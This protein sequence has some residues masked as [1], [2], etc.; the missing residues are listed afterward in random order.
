MKIGITGAGGYIGSRVTKLALEEGY[1]VVPIDNGYNSQVQEV[2]GEKV[3]DQDVRNIEGLKEKFGDVDAIFHLA[4]IT[5]IPECEEKE[6][7]AYEVNVRGTENIARICSENGIPLVF[8]M[9]MQVFGKVKEFPIT[10]E[11]SRRPVNNYGITKT[12]SE[13][14]IELLSK[15]S[16]P[17]YVFIKSNVYGTHEIKDKEIS[18]GTVMNYFLD[19]AKKGEDLTVHSP[20]TQ[21]K[22]FIHVKDVAKAYIKSLDSLIDGN[23]G[24]E[25]YLLAS[26]QSTSIKALA[27]KIKGKAVEKEV[28]DPEVRIVEN[29][30]ENDSVAEKFDVDSSKIKD[31]IAFNPEYTLEDEIEK[32]FQL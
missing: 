2:Q 5:G 10:E 15:D 19:C 27:D 29:P 22:D 14:T 31:E 30:R 13:K 8:P 21:S 1:E 25:A 20:G 4:A 9:S 12:I 28:S 32:K 26:E 16:F 17:V 3:I 6:D 7:L 11:N 23:N 24:K 18:K